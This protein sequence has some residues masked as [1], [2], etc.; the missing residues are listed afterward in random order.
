MAKLTDLSD[1]EDTTEI[2]RFPRADPPLQPGQPVYLPDRGFCE[3]AAVKGEKITVSAGQQRLVVQRN[4]FMTL[5]QAQGNCR[6]AWVIGKKGRLLEGE[7]LFIVRGLSRYGEWQGFLDEHKIPRSTAVGLIDNY[8]NDLARKGRT[9]NPYGYRTS[10]DDGTD[11]HNEQIH[12]SEEEER[13]KFVEKEADKRLGHEP[14]HTPKYWALRI[15]L[16]PPIHE[17]CR[18]RYRR[19]AKGSKKFWRDRAYEFAGAE[20]P[21]SSE[22]EVSKQSSED[23]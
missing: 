1:R 13:R 23:Q 16:P 20:P 3:I 21:S 4:A 5:T 6:F 10:S 8:L 2:K 19:N 11:Q 17:R 22:E 15:K 18:E 12:D 7:K 14:S 9:Q